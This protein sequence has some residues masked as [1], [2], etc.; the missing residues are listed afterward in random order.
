MIRFAVQWKSVQDGNIYWFSVGT[1]G[2]TDPQKAHMFSSLKLAENKLQV[3]THEGMDMWY[4]DVKI[5]T[6]RCEPLGFL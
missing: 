2:T 4:E 5:Q 1:G 6:F 3:Y